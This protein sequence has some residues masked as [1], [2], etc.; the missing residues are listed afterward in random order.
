MTDDMDTQLRKLFAETQ[1]DLDGQVF[2]ARVTGKTRNR[3]YRYIMGLV[4]LSLVLV[5]AV[6]LF[7]IPLPEASLLITQG[8][9]TSLFDLGEGWMAWVFLP[10]NN[11]ASL[12]ILTFKA[13]RVVHNKN[14]CGSWVG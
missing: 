10:I 9:T 14:R 7:A 12:L 11:V 8:L 1:P 4:S 6:W 3:K 5:I 2:T 13:I